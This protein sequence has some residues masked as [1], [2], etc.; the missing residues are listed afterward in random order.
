MC[1]SNRT[2]IWAWERWT[3]VDAARRRATHPAVGPTSLPVRGVLGTLGLVKVAGTID[4]EP[5]Q[6]SFMALGDGRHKLAVTAN[7]RRVIGKEEGASVRV[8]LTTRR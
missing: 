3:L 7:V 5:F 8:H 1:P 4:G 6:G 2:R